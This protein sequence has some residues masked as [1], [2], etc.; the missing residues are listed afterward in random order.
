[1]WWEKLAKFTDIN[2]RFSL[3]WIVAGYLLAF[4]YYMATFDN[5]RARFRNDGFRRDLWLGRSG[6]IDMLFFAT[7][8]FIGTTSYAYLLDFRYPM[9]LLV[10]DLQNRL[11][12]GPFLPT[13][14]AGLALLV[15]FSYFVSRDFASYWWHRLFHEVDLFYCFHACH[16]SLRKMNGFSV[17]R[18]HP[19]D[20][21]GRAF[22]EASILGVF[23]LVKN[24]VFGP[25]VVIFQSGYFWIFLGLY[26]A[27][28]V[29]R[30]TMIWLPFPRILSL[31]LL[32]PAMHLV[33]HSTDPKHAFKNYGTLFSVWDLIFGTIYIPERT[34]FETLE[35]G[36]TE[37]WALNEISLRSLLIG[38]FKQ[39]IVCLKRPAPNDD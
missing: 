26:Y 28:N 8:I 14:D 34:E 23:M 7:L 3:W 17:F 5:A 30:H 33:H 22:F 4:L 1:M 16:H 15:S 36:L 20:I 32:S 19:I 13:S 38:P 11:P 2:Y 35:Y 37:R 21:L 29:I 18:A 39:A 25:S 6:R 10:T 9:G 31:F 27:T 24:I 12:T